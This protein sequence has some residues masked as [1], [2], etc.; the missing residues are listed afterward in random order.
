MS[1]YTTQILFPGIK[2]VYPQL[3]IDVADDVSMGWVSF[4]IVQFFSTRRLFGWDPRP[5]GT[6]WTDVTELVLKGIER[7]YP[8]L[9]FFVDDSVSMQVLG[10]G[11]VKFFAVK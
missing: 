1:A 2:Q 10:V 3:D 4:G 6:P 7:Q 5:A 11:H 9:V 8:V